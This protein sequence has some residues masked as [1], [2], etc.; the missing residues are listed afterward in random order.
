MSNNEKS[1]YIKKLY[2]PEK[3]NLEKEKQKFTQVEEIKVQNKIRIVETTINNNQ[4]RK[5]KLQGD[6]KNN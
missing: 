6:N 3:G 2:K 4:G 5:K 1:D